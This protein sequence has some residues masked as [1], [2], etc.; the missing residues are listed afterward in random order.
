MECK[1][2][3]YFTNVTILRISYI[4]YLCNDIWNMDLYNFVFLSS[5]KNYSMLYLKKLNASFSILLDNAPITRCNIYA[6]LI[7][8][9]RGLIELRV[10][11]LQKYVFDLLFL[12]KL[13][14]YFMCSENS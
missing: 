9:I 1:C 10:I 4:F 13:A 12:Y 11:I 5:V 8:L 7:N 3:K 6:I 2:Y 14:H